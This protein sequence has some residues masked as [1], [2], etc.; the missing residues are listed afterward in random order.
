MHEYRNTVEKLLREIRIF[1]AI[2]ALLLSMLATVLFAS[3]YSAWI[4]LPSIALVSLANFLVAGLYLFQQN[5]LHTI[6]FGDYLGWVYAFYLLFACVSL[7]DLV[8]QRAR[9]TIFVLSSVGL[10]LTAV[11]TC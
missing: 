1:S 11:V 9:W 4:S 10:T 8:F 5:W 3:A 2:N 7:W 6:L